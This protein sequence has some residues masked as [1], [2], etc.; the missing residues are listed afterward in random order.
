MS[1]LAELLV[2]V[3]PRIAAIEFS[4]VVLMIAIIVVIVVVLLAALLLTA[5]LVV[6][7]AIVVVVTVRLQA[8]RSGRLSHTRGLLSSVAGSGP[9]APLVHVRGGVVVV[10][11]PIFVSLP[12]E[13]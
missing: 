11:V 8:V 10:I 12:V 4:T 6:A 9:L 3:R 2:V 13:L 7:A 1:L 5:L